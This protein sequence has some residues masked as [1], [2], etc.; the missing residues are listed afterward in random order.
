M[1]NP[2]IQA[3]YRATVTKGSDDSAVPLEKK[4]PSYMD[5]MWST[6]AWAVGAVVSTSKN[7]LGSTVGSSSARP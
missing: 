3:H 5:K 2:V 6:G 4:A 1:L 7:A